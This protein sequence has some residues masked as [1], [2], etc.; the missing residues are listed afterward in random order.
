MAQTSLTSHQQLSNAYLHNVWDK[1][2]CFSLTE[3]DR[4]VLREPS[5]SSDGQL[6]IVSQG[7][8]IEKLWAVQ[9]ALDEHLEIL[10]FAP[11]NS[12]ATGF[13]ME[14]QV[15]IR[16]SDGL[17][18]KLEQIALAQQVELAVLTSRPSLSRPGLLVMDMDSTVIGVECI[19]EIAKLAGVGDEVSK[20]TEL[21]MQGKL[22]FAQSL[23]Q[24]VAC[25]AGAPESI[26]QQ[27]RD[28]LPIMAGIESMLIQL[29]RAGWKLAIASGGF[30]YFAD[31][32]CER[33]DLD[34]AISNQ[35]SI[36]NGVLTGTV[37]GDIVTANVKAQTLLA[38][39]DRWQIEP[40]QTVA[41]GDGA[42]DLVMMSKAGLGVALHAKPLV[43]QQAASAIRFGG[44]D[45]ILAYFTQ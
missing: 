36:E 16:N 28:A 15:M 18:A 31:Y 4:L 14:A 13:A 9:H 19:D 2:V 38:L 41:M 17:Q 22:D 21:A 30:T 39:A 5:A 45:L 34:Y 25:L 23:T 10:H 44:A 7:L 24:R 8:N 20:V 33:L 43:R 35:L 26:L 40:S 27:V 6:I 1:G 37:E 3:S 12:L 11:G 32:L 29:K 42:N